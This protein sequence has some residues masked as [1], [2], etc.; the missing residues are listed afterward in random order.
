MKIYKSWIDELKAEFR[1]ELKRVKSVDL[2]RTLPAVLSRKECKKLMKFYQN[3]KKYDERNYLA[4]RIL[5]ATGIRIGELSNIRFCDFN[6]ENQTIFIVF[7]FYT[8]MVFFISKILYY[9]HFF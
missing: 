6:Y 4:I 5:Y 9:F 3:G 1:T 7:A 2:S 8:F